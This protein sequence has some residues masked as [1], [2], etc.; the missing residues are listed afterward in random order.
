MRLKQCRPALQSAAPGGIVLGASH[1]HF[2]I[3][4]SP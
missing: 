3:I 1:H 4:T 2:D